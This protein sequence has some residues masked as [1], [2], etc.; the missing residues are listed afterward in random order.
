[1]H[2]VAGVALDHAIDTDDAREWPLHQ[3]LFLKR[4]FE[5]QSFNLHGPVGN[6][7]SVCATRALALVFLK[8]FSFHD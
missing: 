5:V 4:F 2:Y 8:R 7:R 6:L 3:K 1:M